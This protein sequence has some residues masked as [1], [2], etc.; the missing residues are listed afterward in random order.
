M[1]N[2]MNNES[3]VTPP[4][5]EEVEAVLTNLRL[6]AESAHHTESE[7]LFLREVVATLESIVAE[8][9][10]AVRERDEKNEL[11][12]LTEEALGQ[13]TAQ[14]G[15]LRAKLAAAEADRDALRYALT[16]LASRTTNH[17]TRE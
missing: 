7:I 1:E 14:I 15:Q 9:D 4:T 5:R 16:S 8:R 13:K 2:Q 17:L 6:Y 12:L 10:A 11:L 3:E